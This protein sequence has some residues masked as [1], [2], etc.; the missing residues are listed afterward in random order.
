ME[1]REAL[2]D[3]GLATGANW[4]TSYVRPNGGIL[5]QYGRDDNVRWGPVDL[6]AIF[7]TDWRPY[8][9]LQEEL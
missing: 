1:I 2:K 3:T 6:N 5:I 7:D 4:A 9:P 8:N